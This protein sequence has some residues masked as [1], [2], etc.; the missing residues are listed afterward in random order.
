LVRLPGDIFTKFALLIGN[1]EPDINEIKKYNYRAKYRIAVDGGANV[2]SKIEIKPEIVVG[3]FDSIKR[4]MLHKL[5]D[6]GVE[7]IHEPMQ[8]NNDLEKAFNH[9]PD[10]V[11]NIIMI[12]FLGKRLD[13]T[14]ANLFVSKKFI[15]KYKILIS[16]RLQDVYVLSP[17]CYEV[18]TK[19]E[20]LISLFTFD[21]A[22]KLT[23]KGFK[24]NLENCDLLPSSLGLS[25]ISLNDKVIIEFTRGSLILIL[26][27]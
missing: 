5:K 2:L 15:E 14:L 23:L 4:E 18:D 17:R 26:N 22:E 16:D 27:K 10:G 7:I 3:D 6:S 1:S 13:H 9:I 12:G 24:Y 20:Q 21:R 25:N 11:N 19:K 8:D